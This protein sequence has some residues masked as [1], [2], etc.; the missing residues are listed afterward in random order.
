MFISKGQTE[1]GRVCQEIWLMLMHTL[2]QY[3]VVTSEPDVVFHKQQH[4][5]KCG[6]RQR[7]S[8][9]SGRE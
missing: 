5:E 6:K 3:E 7:F 8:S 9:L 2:S 4:L 1:C